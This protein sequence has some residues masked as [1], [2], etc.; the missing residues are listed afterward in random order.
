MRKRNNREINH[1]ISLLRKNG[2]EKSAAQA[3]VLECRHN[4]AQVFDQYVRGVSEDEKTKSSFLPRAMRR[5]I[6][7]GAFPW[8][9]SYPR[10]GAGI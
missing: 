6:W 3:N 7:R 4:E 5:V 1:A 8:R 2:D 9:S 10:R